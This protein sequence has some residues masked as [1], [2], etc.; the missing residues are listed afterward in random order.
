MVAGLSVVL[1]RLRGLVA[2]VGGGVGG[3]VGACVGAC[4]GGVGRV[5]SCNNQDLG[6]R[7]GSYGFGVGVDAVHA[8][9]VVSFRLRLVS[10]R[11][12]KPTKL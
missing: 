4:V 8:P 10:G 12:D 3:C 11:R 1:E 7:A 2:A 6:A 9:Y 5:I